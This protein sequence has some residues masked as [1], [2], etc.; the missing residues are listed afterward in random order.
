[1][2]MASDMDIVSKAC[3]SIF[4]VAI[5]ATAVGKNTGGRGNGALCGGHQYQ[6]DSVPNGGPPYIRLSADGVFGQ[7]LLDYGATG[8]SLSTNAFGGTDRLIRHAD[9]SL[10]GVRDGSFTLRHFDNPLKPVG[11]QLGVV[12]TDILS[13]LTV[14]MTENTVFVGA[15]PCDSNALRA[16]GLVPIAQRDFFS[17]DPS[18]I[19]GKH[20]N[21]PVVFLRLGEVRTWAQIDTGYDDVVYEHSIDINE[22]LFQRLVT[23]G[24]T[25]DHLANINV[26]TCEGVESRHVYTVKDRSILIETDDSTPIMRIGTF[27]LILKPA[28]GCG[29]IGAMSI[30][31]AQLGASFLRTFRTI[32]FDPQLGTVWLEGRAGVE[33]AGTRN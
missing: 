12:G 21:V 14:Q 8:S 29:G 16:R 28:N 1:M 23:E 5:L 4:A 19:D 18:M 10:P 9:L 13:L 6:R 7:F 33:A 17:S 3:L 15:Q 27:Y 22:A 11:R 24:M 26:S 2:S 30:P 25:L 32:V 20:P 31:A